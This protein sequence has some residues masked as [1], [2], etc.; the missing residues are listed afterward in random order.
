MYVCVCVVCLQRQHIFVHLLDAG[1]NH[2]RCLHLS[3]GDTVV[4]SEKKIGHEL[5]WSGQAAVVNFAH[6]SGVMCPCD[7]RNFAADAAA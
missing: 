5:C 7:Q 3:P 2:R 6:D 4:D 1:R